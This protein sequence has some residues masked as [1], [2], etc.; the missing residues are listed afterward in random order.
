M[1]ASRAGSLRI[2]SSTFLRQYAPTVHYRTVHTDEAD[3]KKKLKALG[4]KARVIALKTAKTAKKM[5]MKKLLKKAEDKKTFDVH[6]NMSVNDI[7]NLTGAPRDTLLDVV[8][9]HDKCTIN[10][11]HDPLGNRHILTFIATKLGCKF[12]IVGHKPKDKSEDDVNLDVVHKPPRIKDLVPRPPVVTIVGHIDH[13]KTTLLDRLRRSNVVET[14]FGGITQH[15]GAFS[16]SLKK[17]SKDTESNLMDKVTFLDTPGHAAFKDMRVRG[18]LVTDIVILVVDA[19]EGP[20]DQTFES[21]EAVKKARVS[22]IV[23]LNKIDKPDADVTKTKKALYEAG[24]ALEDFGGE[25][26]AQE[27][28]ALNGTGVDDLIEAVL[29]QAEVLQLSADPKGPVE[30]SVIESFQEQGLGKAAT[31]LVKRGTLKK[32]TVLVCGETQTRVK[33]LLDTKAPISD[34]FASRSELKQVGPAGACRVVGWKDLP[35]VGDIVMEVESEKRAS[36]VVKWR[37]NQRK[38]V[39][40]EEER[41][42]IEEGRH[43]DRKVYEE[44]RLKKLKSGHLRGKGVFTGNQNE[45]R[46]ILDERLRPKENKVSIVVRC[47]VDGSLDAIINCLSTYKDQEVELDILNAAVGEVSETDLMLA[48]EFDGIVYA[49]NIRLPDAIRK[50]A[51]AIYGT[52]IR[53]HNVIY[54]MIDDLKEEIGQKMPSVEK[55]HII[56]QGVVAQEF[57]FHEKK[58][59]VQ[60]AGCRVNKG[61]FDATKLYRITRGKDVLGEGS[62]ESLKHHKA[63]VTVIPNGKD[64]GLRMKDNS[65]RFMPGDVIT[66]YEHRQEKLPV[67]W[68]PGF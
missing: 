43:A 28:S 52:T 32:G 55:E 2:S 4:N 16:V 33:Q 10:S 21:I 63:E 8:L 19:C 23:A 62:L 29:A 45:A 67:T 53:E 1:L 20:L 5:D 18:A 41:M 27:I 40:R 37:I 24:V 64:C 46:A 48:Q 61:M 65:I 44:Y 14:E 11:E 68:S 49:F 17:Y 50:A 3:E 57:I 54:A 7:C 15:I 9:S 34:Q 6:E 25:V 59:E 56:G 36:E 12:K 26:Q 35:H 66:C 31:V 22:L 47:D 42:L 13:G 39:E 38:L 60:V 58:K 30:A 51:S